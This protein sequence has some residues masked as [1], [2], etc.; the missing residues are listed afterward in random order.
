MR[1]SYIYAL[2]ISNP[3]TGPTYSPKTFRQ[4]N[5]VVMPSCKGLDD[6]QTFDK[7]FSAISQARR[8]ARDYVTDVAL[9]KLD[10]DMYDEGERDWV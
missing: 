5:V 6:F 7:M 1:P 9:A 3:E 10:D 4:T 8:N 2:S